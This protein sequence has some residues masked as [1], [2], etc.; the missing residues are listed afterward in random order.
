M[1]KTSSTN[2]GFH[3]DLQQG[4]RQGSLAQ[5]KGLLTVVRKPGGGRFLLFRFMG[6]HRMG[7]HPQIF[8]PWEF[9]E[10]RTSYFPGIRIRTSALKE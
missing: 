2:A 6:R 9:A 8:S 10:P 4:I 3:L 5:D 1:A 7:F